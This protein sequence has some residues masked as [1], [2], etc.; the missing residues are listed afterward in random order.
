ML[1][2]DK[3]PTKEIQKQIVHSL[4]NRTVH[5]LPLLIIGIVIFF[6]VKNILHQ[7]IPGYLLFQAEKSFQAEDVN[8]AISTYEQILKNYPD[9]IE[10]K[11][12]AY[13][14]LGVS[15]LTQNKPYSASASFSKFL[16]SNPPAETLTPQSRFLIGLT[17][18]DTEKYY[19]AIKQLEQVPFSESELKIE[20][21]QYH[22]ALAESYFGKRK[23]DKALIAANETLKTANSASSQARKAHLIKY[24]IFSEEGKDAEAAKEAV[25]IGKIGI[26]NTEIL[27]VFEASFYLDY[28][29]DLAQ[30]SNV[31]KG[32][33]YA[34][35]ISPD[36]NSFQRA[37][38]YT[39]LGSFYHRQGDD[40]SASEYLH[41]AIE[42][43]PDYL[44]AYYTLGG[45]YTAQKDY[46]KALEYDQ[47]A[48][49]IDE[50]DP[51]VRNGLGWA[52]Y[53]LAIENNN[54]NQSQLE[55]SEGHF[56]KAISLDPE[57]AI[58]H[59]NLGLVY[60]ALSQYQ[61]ALSAFQTAIDLD[62]KYKKPYLNIGSTYLDQKEYDRALEYYQKAL[63]I[64][65]DYALAY[66]A[67][68]DFYFRQKKY[69]QAVIPSQQ[70]QKLNP[71]HLD[72][73]KLL[74]EIFM[75]QGQSQKAIEEINKGLK[76]ER[77]HGGFYIALA[78]IY[79]ELGDI[80][81]SNELFAK[82][83]SLQPN[84]SALY[85]YNLGLQLKREGKF[86][87]ARAQL[88]EAINLN[89]QDIDVLIVLAQV[90]EELGNYGEAIRLLEQALTVDPED[91]NI[92][93]NLAAVYSD[94]DDY[95]T[96]IDTYKNGLALDLTAQ[97]PSDV[98]R[99]Y[100]NLGLVYH[101]HTKQ[102]DLAEEAFKNALKYDPKQ[103][104]IYINLA[105]T[106]RAKGMLKEA[107]SQQR[108]ALQL[109][110]E[111]ALAHNNLGYTLALQGNITEAIVEFKKAL[112]IDPNLTIAKDN[113]ENFQKQ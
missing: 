35:Q 69:S 19:Q 9:F 22:I 110:P 8:K 21:S 7:V 66:Y 90:E 91:I 77:D 105:E 20:P 96:A 95:Q 94:K 46:Q 57:F 113:L 45:L 51:L 92:Y 37:M 39:L 89:P 44:P 50:N 70:A 108:I 55:I 107:V 10:K 59:G 16:A 63:E 12:S 76:V 48:M 29:F 33:E 1:T 2:E 36:L 62:P 99:V 23:F 30:S 41:K 83:I 93:D 84:L 11:P 4:I 97:D 85:Q 40:K 86:K 13:Y 100:E 31:L 18:N 25:A 53:N 60:K 54:Y 65:P 74:A 104:T 81:R 73:Y 15:Y 72:T 98:G 64:D 88:I 112:E 34:I 24:L 87:E 102:F 79:K 14:H 28:L 5:I 49:Q 32:V 111:N 68:G 42:T 78:N 82:G 67:I 58:G 80:K 106:Y 109:E 17:F 101:N 3:T 71:N 38:V 103:A 27:S 75:A 26:K 43:D 6:L 47:Q 61:D 52:Y 56:K